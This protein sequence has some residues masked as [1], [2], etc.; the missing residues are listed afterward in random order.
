MNTLLVLPAV[1]VLYLQALGRD[2]AL[3]QALIM[4]QMQ[5]LLGTPFLSE[6]P[7]SYLA[8][9]FE[10]TRQFLFE[11]TVNWRFVGEEMFLSRTFSLG[12]LA[13]H[14]ALLF[15]FAVTR[16]IKS[17]PPFSPPSLS[18]FLSTNTPPS[19]QTLATL[20]PLLHRPPHHP[21]RHSRR[22]PH[23]RPRHAPLHPHVRPRGKHN[24]HAVRAQPALPVLL[25][26]RVGNTLRPVA[27]RVRAR[28]DHRL[29]GGPGVG[30]ECVS[31]HQ[32]E[33]V[34]GGGESWGS[35][36]RGVVGG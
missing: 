11:W 31:Q 23:Q 20:S 29:V 24:R 17:T 12:L 21:R 4:V 25:V 22:P 33:L 16:W 1:A 15:V 32:R 35:A 26:A 10:F 27:Q 13:L 2:S 34:H 3:R 36:G 28:V 9:A 8:G 18:L 5:F 30:M 6:A 19:T 14:A 7:R